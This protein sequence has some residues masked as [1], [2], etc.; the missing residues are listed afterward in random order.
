MTDIIINGSNSLIQDK[1][2]LRAK[3][4]F[5]VCLFGVF[6]FIIHYTKISIFAI[7]A[8]S[9]IGTLQSD[10]LLFLHQ[11]FFISFHEIAR[12]RQCQ[13]YVCFIGASLSS[14]SK[15]EKNNLYPR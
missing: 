1:S 8:C 11:R 12:N 2:H 10:V 6:L 3:H 4:Y 9:G 15:N 7:L 14:I 5:S 13:N